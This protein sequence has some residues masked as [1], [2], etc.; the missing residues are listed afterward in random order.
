MIIFYNNNKFGV[1][2]LDQKIE[3]NTCR[4]RCLHWPLNV[5]F[6]LLDVVVQ[7][8]FSIFFYKQRD[9]AHSKNFRRDSF[10]SLATD[11]MSECHRL[12][13][14]ASNS[15]NGMH[16]HLKHSFTRLGFSLTRKPRQVRPEINR[17]RCFDE[18][19]RALQNNNRYNLVCNVCSITFCKDHCMKTSLIT[20]TC[21]QI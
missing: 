18:D 5:F 10:E 11:L 20:C 19:C 21:M 17:K 12:Q 3:Y 14:S 4:R 8:T 7:N 9:L 6:F 15:Y 1:D 13:N 16:N 2:I